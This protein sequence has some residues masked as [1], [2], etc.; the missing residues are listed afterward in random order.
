MPDLKKKLSV[1]IAV[2]SVMPLM[3]GVPVDLQSLGRALVDMGDYSGDCRYEVLLPTS[4]RPVVYDIGLFSRSAVGDTLAPADYVIDWAVAKDGNSSHGFS[5]YADGHHYRFRGDRLQEYHYT[6]DT[7]PFAP[8]GT[9]DGGVQNNA[10][11]TDLLPQYIGQR[12]ESMAVDSSYRCNYMPDKT[13][14]G[15]RCIVVDGVRTFGGVEALEFVYAF[16]R[17]TLMPVSADFEANPGQIGEQTITVTYSYPATRIKPY[18][19]I[20]EDALMSVYADAFGN[21]RESDFRLDNMPGRKLPEL[22]APTVT[23]ERYTRYKG[24]C[25]AVPTVI[26]ILDSDIGSAGATVDALRRAVDAMPMQT[27]VIFAFISNDID[28]IEALTGP[29]REGEHILMSARRLARDCGVTATPVVII[30][31]RD[32]TVKE[33]INGYNNDLTDVVIQKTVTSAVK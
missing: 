18:D 21:C 10:Q 30:C 27:D 24:D 9:V 22:T 19:V 25:F 17:E 5:A 1:V 4:R 13:V 16:D 3:G 32:A 6:D 31:D 15:R 11:F 7:V 8:R 12:F 26:A 2:A 20:T 28:A 23:G 33:I 29:C 14:N